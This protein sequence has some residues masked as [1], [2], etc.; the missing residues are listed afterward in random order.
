[1][2]MLFGSKG[3]AGDTIEPVEEEAVLAVVVELLL[4]LLLL[5][6]LLLSLEVRSAKTDLSNPFGL[7]NEGTLEE[8]DGLLGFVLRS[9]SEGITMVR[10]F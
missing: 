5:L 7:N 1:M 2:L 9:L 6:S 8:E 3:V 4:L 10:G